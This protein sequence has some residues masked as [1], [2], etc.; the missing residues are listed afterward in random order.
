VSTITRET[1]ETRV[2]IALGP[3]PAE[4]AAIATGDA[5]LDHMLGTL[6][7]YAD[8]P[9]RVEARGDLR[10]HLVED[11]AITLGTILDRATP[12]TCARYG[13]AVVPMD[14]ALVEAALDAGGRP[15]FEGRLPSRLYEHFFR[16]LALHARWTLHVRVV[17]GRDRHHIV[18]AAFKALGLALRQARREDGAVFSTKGAV[19]VEWEEAG[20]AG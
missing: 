3:A 10:H 7:R 17:R 15:H 16:S 2:R 19:A 12:A 6:A 1:K 20:D 13:H 11:V 8:I 9:L 5:F 14:D 4:S 18:E